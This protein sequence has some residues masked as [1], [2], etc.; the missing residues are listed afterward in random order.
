MCVN[1]CVLTEIE[2]SGQ[3]VSISAIG[4]HIQTSIQISKCSF[5][6]EQ[7]K[8]TELR[9]TV[10]SLLKTFIMNNTDKEKCNPVI[11]NNLTIWQDHHYLD[12]MHPGLSE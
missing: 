9:A 7:K 12:L 6:N 11:W 4:E 10:T 3:L 1:F 5:E 2:A 8:H